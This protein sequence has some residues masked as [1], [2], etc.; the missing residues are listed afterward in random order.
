MKWNTPLK[1]GLVGGLLNVIIT[2]V[3]YFFSPDS[4]AAMWLGM[5]LILTSMF[6]M[7]WGGISYRR[8]NNNQVSFGNAFMSVLIVAVVMTLVSSLFSYIL[9]NVIDTE[10]P[11]LIKQKTIE[12]TQAWM[13]KFNTPED[14]VDEVIAQ[15]EE[16]DFKFDLSEYA[17]RFLQGL[18]IYIILGAIIALF[19]KRNPDKVATNELEQLGKE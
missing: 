2:F 18:V 6:F 12:N 16:Q 8:E 17:F 9:F 4:L 14:K 15:I 3:V 19:I 5:V 10:L 11:E 7:I 1:W 13:E